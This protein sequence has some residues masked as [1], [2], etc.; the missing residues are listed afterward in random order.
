MKKSIRNKIMGG[1]LLIILLLIGLG[2]FSFISFSN[3]HK[4]MNHMT[5]LSFEGINTAKDLEIASLEKISSLRGYLLTSD[6]TYLDTFQDYQTVATELAEKTIELSYTEETIDLSTKMNVLN[7]EY[8]VL[9]D[10]I[11]SLHRSGETTKAIEVMLKQSYPK[12]MELRIASDDLITLKNDDIEI[13]EASINSS[14]NN[15]MMLTIGI[16]GFIIILSISIGTLVTKSIVS[17]IKKLISIC[18][19]VANGDLTQDISVNTKDEIHTLAEA[20]NQMVLNLRNIIHQTSEASEQVA[21]TSQQLSASCQEVSATS[22]EVTSSITEIARVS[23][24]QSIIVNDSTEKVTDIASNIHEVS[25]NIHIINESSKTTLRTAEDGIQ[26]VKEAVEKMNNIKTSTEEASN[27]IQQ[28]NESSKEIEKIVDAISAI[29]DQTNLLALNAAIEAA[30]AGEAGSG[31]AVVAEE[32]RKL[33]EQSGDFAN[34]IG[35]LIVDIQ[36]RIEGTVISITNNVDE[37][38]TGAIAVDI[39][40]K[41]FGVIVS[42]INSVAMKAQD[43]THL[44]DIVS[45]NIEEIVNGFK[46]ISSISQNIASST[47]EIATGSEEQAATIE[48]VANSASYL[49]AMAQQ[50]QSSIAI[51]KY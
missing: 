39:A 49:S 34:K 12:A 18:E 42:E 20:Y 41:N 27:S 8:D 1:F 19:T 13:I 23:D 6:P 16:I 47:E 31:F 2:T 45:Q 4:Q 9:A 32:V 15:I 5:Q 43:A 51:F 36:S 11:F 26:S 33:A 21:S 7:K 46:N 40:S 17:P 38:N 44:T 48:E 28:L 35:L 29:A 37:V 10:S 30:R 3:I 24:D 25:N 22:E 50:L 14:I